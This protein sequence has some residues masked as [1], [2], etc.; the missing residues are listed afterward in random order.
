MRPRFG[1]PTRVLAA[2][3][4]I[5]AIGAVQASS[6]DS[7]ARVS[8]TVMALVFLSIGVGL[9]L[10]YLWAWWLAVGLTA[11]VA[12]L[13]PVVHEPSGGWILWAMGLALLAVSGVQ[14]YRDARHQP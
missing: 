6:G 2:A 14:G 9:W 4:V 3:F 5:A 1:T 13:G 7:F 12:V 11:F 8:L 10:E